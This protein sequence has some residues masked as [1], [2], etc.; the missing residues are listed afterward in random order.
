[1]AYAFNSA[2]K[3]INFIAHTNQSAKK[4]YMAII[5]DYWIKERQKNSLVNSLKTSFHR[6]HIFGWTPDMQNPAKQK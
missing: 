4:N 6:P 1:M 3:L 2:P 5:F